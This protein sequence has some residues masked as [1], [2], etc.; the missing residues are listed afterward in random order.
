MLKALLRW[1]LQPDEI[2]PMTE[3]RK[4]LLIAYDMRRNP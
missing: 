2:V 3:E 1:F 4:R